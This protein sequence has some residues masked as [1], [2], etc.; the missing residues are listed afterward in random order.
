MLDFGVVEANAA[1]I[2]P[3]AQSG[4]LWRIRRQAG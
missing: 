1:G 4:I 2:I 3:W